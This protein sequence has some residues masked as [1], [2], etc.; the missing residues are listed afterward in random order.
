[1]SR[2]GHGSA[3]RGPGKQLLEL[4]SKYTVAGCGFPVPLVFQTPFFM[5]SVLQIILFCTVVM[6]AHKRSNDGPGFCFPQIG[7]FPKIELQCWW[8][9]FPLEGATPVERR[10]KPI[11]PTAEL[12]SGGVSPGPSSGRSGGHPV[13]STQLD[14]SRSP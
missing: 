11:T 1:M 3:G 2:D 6:A 12:L 9:Y 13:V 4:S 7:R 8:L 5:L 10:L 14:F